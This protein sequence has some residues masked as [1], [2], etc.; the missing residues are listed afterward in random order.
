VYG[1]VPPTGVDVTA[2]S[3]EPKQLICEPLKFDVTLAVVV[4]AAVGCVIIAVVVIEQPNA[5]VIV[6]VAVPAVNKVAVDVPS[7][8]LHKNVYGEVAPDAET[9]AD[10]LLK[11]KHETLLLTTVEAVS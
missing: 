5:S 8:L 2:P 6:T 10:A 7:P 1:L 3:D 9:V 4:W 11:P